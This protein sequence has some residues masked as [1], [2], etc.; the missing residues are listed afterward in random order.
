MFFL[1]KNEN[2]KKIKIFQKNVFFGKKHDFLE[3]L[4]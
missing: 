1:E 4:W 2:F 3:K